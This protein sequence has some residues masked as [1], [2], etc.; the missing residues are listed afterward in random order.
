[1]KSH[2][3]IGVLVVSLLLLIGCSK[4]TDSDGKKEAENK[5]SEETNYEPTETN[6]GKDTVIEDPVAE[7]V[8]PSEE[9]LAERRKMIETISM[10]LYLEKE[11]IITE[12]LELHNIK[13]EDYEHEYAEVKDR[14]DNVNLIVDV[15]DEPVYVEESDTKATVHLKLR[16][17]A[18]KLSEGYSFQNN[19]AVHEY[20]MVNVDGVWKIDSRRV[21][22]ETAVEID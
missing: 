19:E 1:M 8:E 7:N 10:S 17:R 21:L 22:D 6:E 12:Y 13:E 20:K 2:K 4:E 15:I 14:F 3:V 16:R 18:S 11:K 9:L 5:Q